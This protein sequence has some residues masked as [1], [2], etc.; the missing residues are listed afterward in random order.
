MDQLLE[1]PTETH[2]TARLCKQKDRWVPVPRLRLQLDDLRHIFACDECL[3]SE[4]CVCPC[5]EAP[6]PCSPQKRRYMRSSMPEHQ[7]RLLATHR[8]PTLIFSNLE[9]LSSDHNPQEAGSFSAGR[10]LDVARGHLFFTD[11]CNT[12]HEGAVRCTTPPGAGT[13][14]WYTLSVGGQSG[15]DSQVEE[16][17]S[18][19]APHIAKVLPSWATTSRGVGTGWEGVPEA[20]RTSESTPTT[21]GGEIVVLQGTSFGHHYPFGGWG[22]GTTEYGSE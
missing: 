19:R 20:L 13:D 9:P 5:E 8:A 1:R 17:P 16:G 15:D 11:V 12:L 18:Y 3:P 14:F 21:E 22:E 4:L 6:R 2:D 10:L 7:W